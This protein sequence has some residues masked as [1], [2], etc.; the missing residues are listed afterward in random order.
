MARAMLDKRNQTGESTLICSTEYWML[1]PCDVC[2]V[3]VDA[4]VDVDV[5]MSGWLNTF[6]T[7][8]NETITNDFVENVEKSTASAFSR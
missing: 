1:W 6:S 5:E 4:D 3:D 8:T 2:N 7:I